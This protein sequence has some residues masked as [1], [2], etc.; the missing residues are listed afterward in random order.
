MDNVIEFPAS[1]RVIE[2]QPSRVT[3]IFTRYEVISVLQQQ[4]DL[5]REG[6]ILLM[7]F[8]AVRDDHCSC[9]YVFTQRDYESKVEFDDDKI[10]QMLDI[11]IAGD[12]IEPPPKPA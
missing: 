3:E 1:K 2:A 7:A 10:E 6:K 5:I 11:W 4:I 12:E 9:Q 8:T